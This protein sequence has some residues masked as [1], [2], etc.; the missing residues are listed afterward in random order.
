[1]AIAPNKIDRLKSQLLTS[2]ISQQNNALY[3]VINQLIDALKELITEFNTFSG[4]SGGGGGSATNITEIINNYMLMQ[5][6]SEGSEGDMGPQGIQGINGIDGITG[7]AGPITIGPMGIDGQD[8]D[9]GWPIPGPAGVI[10]S[11]APLV[12]LKTTATQTINA[13]AGVYVDITNLTFPVINGN[14]YGFKFYIVFQSAN[15]LTGQK[16]SV[17]CPTGTLDFFSTHQTVGNSATV[18]V[19]TWLQ[20]HSVTRDDMTT[21]TGTITAAVDLVVMIEG[22]YICTA[23]GT[24]AARFANELVTNTDIVVQAG[25]WGYYWQQ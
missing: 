14:T 23:D 5:G 16:C 21:L 1:M 11:N 6:S 19:A 17:N 13:G 15:V 8:G 22:R 18:G 4:G 24:F 10:G 9:D 20:R 25:S 12:F 7:S 2:G 3:Q